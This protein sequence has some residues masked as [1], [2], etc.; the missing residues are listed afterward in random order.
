MK[1]IPI[2]ATIRT[3]SGKGSARRTRRDGKIPAVIYGPETNPM[4][5]AI[6]AREFRAAMKS[7]SGAGSIFD[8]NLD[9]KSSKAIVRE[10]QRDPIT[11]NVIHVDLF[12]ISM[13][14]PIHISVPV[15]YVGTPVGVKTDGGIMQVTM[16][17]LEISCLPANIP[18]SVEIDVT[19]LGIGDSIHVRDVSIPEAKIIAE[20][21]RTMV[22]ISAPTV[23]KA[24]ATAE[25]EESEEG[26]EGEAEEAEGP[27][28]GEA[29]AAAIESELPEKKTKRDRSERTDRR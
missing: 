22:V 2:S 3:E 29:A 23:I 18:D 4:T 16:R 28:E 19:E 1:E 10:I 15:K 27:T 9:G 14:K 5:L 13:S 6:D 25:A 11:S 20:G 7:A 8:L 12:A 21:R 17:D 26:V 24:E